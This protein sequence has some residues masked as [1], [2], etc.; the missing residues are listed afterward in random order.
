MSNRKNVPTDDLDISLYHEV[1]ASHP[2]LTD[3]S[4]L[5]PEDQKVLLMSGIDPSGKERSGSF[6]Q[7][8]HSVIH[9]QTDFEG[10]EI[11]SA[12][13]AREK[14][15]WLKD[16]WGK[17]VPVDKDYYTRRAEEHQEHGYFIRSLP[18]AEVHYPL[19]A[20]LY[21]SEDKL[22]QDVHNIVIA[23]EGSSLNIITG[24]ATAPSVRSGL[25]VGVS[26]F[27]VKKGATLSFTM[28]H[29]WAEEMAVRPRSAVIVEEGGTY[30]SNYICLVPARDLQMYPTTI[31]RGKGAVATINTVLLA[32]PGS[33]MD[34][35]SRVI[36]QA[37]ECKAEIISRAVS[38]GGKIIARGDLVGEKPGIK[39]HLECKGLLLSD[40]GVIHSIPELQG[41]A[42]NLDMS[43]EAAI[44][45]IAQEEI[46][47]LMSRG[48]SEHE[49]TSLIV[50]GFLSLDI[51][52]LPDDLKKE[53]NRMIDETDTNA[54]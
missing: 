4:Q 39:A 23:E 25:H 24:C 31:L 12:S 8:D 41:R 47:Y 52:G 10:A 20:C 50:K 21:L 46:E 30:I 54:M 36:L 19:Q 26:E 32:T 1:A 9:C 48:L 40:Q 44:G 13:K 51:I 45:K 34:V 29:N 37:E 53:L 7:K 28:I 17:A 43:H 38:T 2:E 35:G 3:L 42:A 49:A 27:Y 6:F 15:A 18:G 5:S 33:L 16:Y 22:A 11:I 14:Y